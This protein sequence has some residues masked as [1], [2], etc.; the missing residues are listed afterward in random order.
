MDIV[1]LAFPLL[2]GRGD[3]MGLRL[4]VT[5]RSTIYRIIS[6]TDYRLQYS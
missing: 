5:D 4:L 3:W 6:I 1:L 2:I